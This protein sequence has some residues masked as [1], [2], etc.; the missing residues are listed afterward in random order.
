MRYFF[1]LC[2]LIFV[3]APIFSQS[4][5][6]VI[7][8]KSTKENLEFANVFINNSTL[9]TTSDNKGNFEL[10]GIP[11]GKYEL[12]ISFVGYE[13]AIYRVD[14]ASQ[15]VTYVEIFLTPSV[16]ELQSIN[17]KIDRDKAWES[18]FS[19]FKGT[20][21][22]KTSNAT[23]CKILNPW[24]IDLTENRKENGFSASS[25]SAIEIENLGLGYKIF[26]YLQNF[27][28]KGSNFSLIG[29][30]RFESL[31]PK[32]ENEQKKYNQNRLDAYQGS[33]RHF[34][35]S[36]IN[37]KSKEEG[38]LIYKYKE[39]RISEVV[40]PNFYQ[41]LAKNI[42]PYFPQN[43]VLQG[44]Q[45]YEYKIQLP[46]K[47]EIHYTKK[48]SFTPTYQDNLY[49]VSWLDL[50][51]KEVVSNENGIVTNPLSIVISGDMSRLRVADMLPLNYEPDATRADITAPATYSE[52][53]TYQEKGYLHTDRPY[54]F[55][56]EQVWFKAYLKYIIPEWQD[57]LSNV[58]YIELIS[59]D[60]KI[61]ARKKLKIS[62][63]NATGNFSLPDSIQGNFYLR[64]YTN[65]MRNFGNSG[66]ALKTIPVLSLLE[67]I[68]QNED[69]LIKE[70]FP[71]LIKSDKSS[72]KKRE[73]IT[74]KIDVP[75]NTEGDIS[76]HLSVS[77][78]NAEVVQSIENQ[79]NIMSM[80]DTILPAYVPQEIRYPVEIGMA[81]HGKVIHKKQEAAKTNILVFNT[82]NKD[83]LNTIT[84]SNGSFSLYGLDVYGK[85]PLIFQTLDEKN[86]PLI[87]SI[88]TIDS[89]NIPP[90]EIPQDTIMS[91]T[92]I[93][94][95]QPIK[96]EKLFKIDSD[97]TQLKAVTVKGTKIDEIEEI[98]QKLSV[99]RIYGKPDYVVK[100][101]ELNVASNGMN[102]IVALQGRVPGL[103]V[104]QFVN[105]GRKGDNGVLG[106]VRYKVRIRG[107]ANSL[108][109]SYE[110]LVMIDGIL[111]NPSDDNTGYT[112]FE[113]L[114][115]ISLSNIDRIEVVT[116]ATPLYGSRGTNGIIAVYT[117]M[118][119]MTTNPKEYEPLSKA[120][121][122][123]IFDGFTIPLDFPSPSY[124]SS[125]EEDNTKPDNRITLY[126]NPN[127]HTNLGKQAN[128]SFY[129]NDIAGL[130]RIEVEGML[131]DG[132]VGRATYFFEVE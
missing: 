28:Q 129:A 72:Y 5:K 94:N 1:I 53:L 120:N 44:A 4:I 30:V 31:I 99:T 49:Q 84:D 104:T 33:E 62:N 52:L 128:V 63:G 58:L 64:A 29:N 93:Q 113:Q 119:A 111:L 9:G 59:P 102:P 54:Y 124:D 91:A 20:F 8:D 12:V 60:L 48:M 100:S 68:A 43:I 105:D 66:F 90:L 15:Q 70:G 74:L 27:E 37:G 32:D 107:G 24:V 69:G 35:K 17:V 131:S 109:M 98:Q 14:V 83:I 50:K 55:G 106:Q 34:L 79:K 61:L 88:I 115:A 10:K 127:I 95:K 36:L 21:L 40:S 67:N 38:F 2:L 26:F 97:V 46:P 7:R 39:D 122:P 132:K 77:V 89:L 81:L 108:M 78:T 110:P 126:W 23:S 73:K 86:K 118:S 65:L 114:E 22:G 75:Q 76:A 92:K 82:L 47:I 19:K 71:I 56:G 16:K 13:S 51:E 25:I 117:K 80:S 45:F 6:G 41:H 18:L 3:Y 123:Y 101:D 87:N 42:Q 57:S 11:L 85:I 116:R 96:I 112:P 103:S 125:N 130:Y 121:T